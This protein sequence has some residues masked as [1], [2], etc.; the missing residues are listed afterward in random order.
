VQ[1]EKWYQEGAVPVASDGTV[2]FLSYV[3]REKGKVELGS[4]ACAMCHTRVM[5]DG[6]FIRGAQGNFNL[7]RAQSRATNYGAPPEVLRMVR[8]LLW[9]VPWLK[10]DPLDQQLAMTPDQ[11]FKIQQ[12]LPA[13]VQSRHR[14]SPVYPVQVPDLIGVRD[15]IYLDR[16]GLQLHRSI[17]DLMRYAALN[18]GGDFLADFD[19]FIPLGGPDFKKLSD[20]ANPLVGGRYS[21]EQLYALALYVYSLRPPE[22]P[23]KMDAMAVKGEKLFQDEGCPRRV[24]CRRFTRITS[25]RPR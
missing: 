8:R 21:D 17:V 16:T 6:S 23:H 14:A 19:G 12:M 2:P 4:F 11:L 18:Q 5:P 9:A 20:P 3:I 1:N 10:P 24:M 15:R 13:G 22:N 7:E 25:L